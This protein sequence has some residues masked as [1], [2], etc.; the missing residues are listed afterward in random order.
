MTNLI[1]RTGERANH[2]LILGNNEYR[3]LDFSK[4]RSGIKFSIK[5]LPLGIYIVKECIK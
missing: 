1:Y 5:K 3:F 4:P 2:R